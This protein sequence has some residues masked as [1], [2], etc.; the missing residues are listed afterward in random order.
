MAELKNKRYERIAV[1]E[2]Y[3]IPEIAE[4]QFRQ[5]P[6]RAQPSPMRKHIFDSLL[7]LGEGRIKT[8]DE[9]GI[10]MQ[11]CLLAGIAHPGHRP[12]AGQRARGARQRP[13]PGLQQ[14]A[15]R[16]H[17]RARRALRRAIPSAPPASSSAR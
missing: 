4:F 9:D 15:S 17:R 10:Q 13:H 12:G 7:D 8:M 3:V 6:V 2:A 5:M 14:E 11:V 16:P 1:E